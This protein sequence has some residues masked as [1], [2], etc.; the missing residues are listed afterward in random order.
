V[1]TINWNQIQQQ[2]SLP[3]CGYG[4]TGNSGKARSRGFELQ[5]N[6]R[7][8]PEL[9]WGLGFG[10]DDAHITEQGTGTPQT[11]GS[12]IYQVPRVTIS[13]DLEYEHNLSTEWTG[14]ARVDWSHIG[15]SFSANNTQINPLRR[16][17][18][19]IANLRFGARNDRWELAAFVK[20][21]TN[22][23]ANLG[24][25]ILIGAG[26][27][28]EPRFVINRPLTAGVEARLRFK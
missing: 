23:R 25:A 17:A 19:N 7:L 14:F 22:T 5:S 1:F 2:V 4:L 11:V 15:E 20:N 13:S 27:P 21:L 16:G 8:L 10:Y 9:T 18:Y 24:D 6:A 26:I 12:P 28:G 3:L